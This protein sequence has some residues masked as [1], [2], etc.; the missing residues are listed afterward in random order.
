[1]AEVQ[2]LYEG[3]SPSAGAQM[4]FS[5]SR[6]ARHK[7]EMW[8]AQGAGTGTGV[9]SGTLHSESVSRKGLIW[10]NTPSLWELPAVSRQSP[11]PVDAVGEFLQG[12]QAALTA[13]KCSPD[14]G[15]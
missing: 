2:G 1:M 13:P 6:R 4:L 9:F 3:I 14:C 15:G 8:Q 5:G 12:F 10:K 7:A 11:L